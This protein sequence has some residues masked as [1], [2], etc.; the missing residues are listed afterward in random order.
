MVPKHLSLLIFLLL[1]LGVLFLFSRC[2]QC[3]CIHACMYT[4]AMLQQLVLRIFLTFSLYC[5]RF[6]DLPVL[7]EAS[8]MLRLFSVLS[9][10]AEAGNMLRIQFFSSLWAALT[11]YLYTHNMAHIPMIFMS[12]QRHHYDEVFTQ[13]PIYEITRN[14]PL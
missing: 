14:P 6:M 7:S 1:F 5:Q 13:N 3:V 9:G 11:S 2:V 10:L 8:N 4:V 12:V